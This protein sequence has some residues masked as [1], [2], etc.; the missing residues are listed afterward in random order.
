M[1][2]AF[3]GGRRHVANVFEMDMELQMRDLPQSVW[4]Q[5]MSEQLRLFAEMKY[6]ASRQLWNFQTLKAPEPKP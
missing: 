5:F 1:I 3:F 6:L 2:V 4:P